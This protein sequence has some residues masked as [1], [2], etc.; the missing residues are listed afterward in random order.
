MLLQEK[1]FHL[2]QLRLVEKDIAA[3]EQTI[4]EAKID[5]LKTLKLAHKLSNDY[6][7]LLAEV[8][9]IRTNLGLLSLEDKRCPE[10]VAL[11]QPLTTTPFQI[12]ASGVPGGP[13]TSD[14]LESLP[15]SSALSQEHIAVWLSAFRHGD[16]SWAKQFAAEVGD[17]SDVPSS[18]FRK[19]ECQAHASTQSLRLNDAVLDCGISMVPQS[20]TYSGPPAPP[21]PPPP[22]SQTQQQ[23][24]P[25][26][27]C[28]ACQQLIHR[29]APICPLCK[30]KSRSR[31]PKRPKA[32]GALAQLAS[33]MITPIPAATPTAVQTSTPPSNTE[34]A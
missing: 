21:L 3:I 2:E 31:H 33:T 27:T 6:S 19:M 9:N 24:P 32:R 12:S 28:Q 1:S 29:N 10:A 25:M 34:E 22:P 14:C 16:H 17:L 23:Q 26:K 13:L 5:K 4:F 15:V 8:N 20:S 7:E 18:N 11:I 30:T